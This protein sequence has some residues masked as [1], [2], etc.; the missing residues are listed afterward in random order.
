MP[1]GRAAI[2][3]DGSVTNKENRI[4]IGRVDSAADGEWLNSRPHTKPL[5]KQHLREGCACPRPLIKSDSGDPLGGRPEKQFHAHHRS[6]AADAGV[7]DH[8]PIAPKDL[9]NRD[10]G[11]IESRRRE[12]V[13]KPT[14]QVVRKVETAVF[15][16]IKRGESMHK[17][18]RVEVLHR[19][20]AYS[21]AA[22]IPSRSGCRSESTSRDFCEIAA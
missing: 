17:R 18:L 11:H 10:Q 13:S 20:H 22:H 2:G 14:G 9:N 6:A 16:T 5:R 3:A 4:G 15:A 8:P 1:V 19:T 21:P 12:L 7:G